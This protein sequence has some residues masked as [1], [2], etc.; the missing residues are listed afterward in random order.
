MRAQ[1]DRIRR[2]PARHI[3]I[4]EV[5]EF[6]GF[7]PCRRA[8]QTGP[9]LAQVEAERCQLRQEAHSVRRVHGVDPGDHG[10]ARRLP[11]ATAL[12]ETFAHGPVEGLDDPSSRRAEGRA[13]DRQGGLRAT[14]RR[15]DGH[16][17]EQARDQGRQ[18][19]LGRLGQGADQASRRRIRAGR[20][21]D[22]ANP[23]D[24][25]RRGL[26]LGRRIG[27]ARGR[28]RPAFRLH[29]RPIG[30]V[31]CRPGRLVRRL[32]RSVAFDLDAGS[33]RWTEHEDRAQ[34][35]S[36]AR[37]VL[38]DARSHIGRPS[39]GDLL[40]GRR[41][42][43]RFDGPSRRLGLVARLAVGKG[44]LVRQTAV[45]VVKLLQVLGQVRSVVA[46]IQMDCQALRLEQRRCLSRPFEP[47]AGQGRR[48][49]QDGRQLPEQVGLGPAAFRRIEVRRHQAAAGIAIGD[50]AL[51]QLLLDP[52]FRQA[53][54]IENRLG[55]F[56]LLGPVLQAGEQSRLAQGDPAG[57]ER[58][59]GRVG[60]L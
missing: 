12:I 44:R 25:G 47:G 42:L 56:D 43:D 39:L 40:I 9:V 20:M 5:G 32:R 24:L 35:L 23:V 49:Q 26:G 45:G 1:I 53:V 14:D 8:H 7:G 17:P 33:Q 22:M 10:P 15:P 52:P 21:Q 58:L 51:A 4:A 60:Q 37:L 3:R 48:I 54:A 36:G 55:Q 13:V 59:Q 29:L 30:P 11:S 57:L 28:P 27:D 46:G 34:A 19:N 6:G 18:R 41:G 2:P 31:L 50:P 38:G 16:G